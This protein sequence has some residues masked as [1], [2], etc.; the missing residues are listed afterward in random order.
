M[1]Q[2]HISKIVGKMPFE[3]LYTF[4]RGDGNGSE[5]GL[6]EYAITLNELK[7]LV[8]LKHLI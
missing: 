3:R 8:L 5:S 2:H 1:N 6:L 7:A 4:M